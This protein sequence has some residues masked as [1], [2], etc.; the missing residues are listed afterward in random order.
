MWIPN[1]PNTIYWKHCFVL[2]FPN[3][4]VCWRS[5]GHTYKGLFL[6][7]LLR[8]LPSEPF[9]HKVKFTNEVTTHLRGRAISWEKVERWPESAGSF[10]F[11]IGSVLWSIAWQSFRHSRVYFFL[12]LF[13][14]LNVNTYFF[15]CLTFLILHICVSCNLIL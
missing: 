2:F 4:V 9:T 14:S 3:W 15:K 11:I 8:L 13:F 1:F 6:G 10:S 12:I 7:P 5:F